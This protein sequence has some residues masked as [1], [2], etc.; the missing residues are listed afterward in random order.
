M[1]RPDGRPRRPAVFVDR[2][3]VLNLNR[4]DYVKSVA[5]FTPLPGA[6]EAVRRL[7]EA[8][9]A[10]VVV[11]NQS[12]VGRGLM[13]ADALEAI[14]ARLRAE[15]RAAGGELGGI[16]VCPHRPDEAC[17]CRKPGTELIERALAELDLEREGSW[18]V[19]D[20]EAD[21]HAGRAAGLR[22]VFVASDRD[23]GNGAALADL[24]AM[25]LLQAAKLL[26]LGPARDDRAPGR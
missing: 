6:G 7:N 16:Y 8:G 17:S 3:G 18:M 22:T 24:V 21:I 26:E 2:D 20:A 23:S 13:S 11:T 12:A 19:G 9:Y 15:V 1:P 14:H 25:S 5:E 4:D 10:V